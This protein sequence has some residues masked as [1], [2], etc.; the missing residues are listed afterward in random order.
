M[1]QF[2]V[3]DSYYV[4]ISHEIAKIAKI[5]QFKVPYMEQF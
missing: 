5:A 1:E 2:W 3:M 4:S